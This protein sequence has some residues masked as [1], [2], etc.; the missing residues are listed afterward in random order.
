[1]LFSVI[2]LPTTWSRQCIS[3]GYPFCARGLSRWTSPQWTPSRPLLCLVGHG[4]NRGFRRTSFK[5]LIVAMVSY[6]ECVAG[7]CTAAYGGQIS[8]VDQKRPMGRLKKASHDLLCIGLPRLLTIHDLLYYDVPHPATCPRSTEKAHEWLWCSRGVPLLI[9]CLTGHCFWKHCII[10]MVADFTVDAHWNEGFGML[11]TSRLSLRVRFISR[12]LSLLV[13]S[14]SLFY[15]LASGKERKLARLKLLELS[16]TSRKR[17]NLKHA[18][19]IRKAT[20]Q[21]VSTCKQARQDEGKQARKQ[22]GKQ[23]HRSKHERKQEKKN[24]HVTHE[25]W[26]GKEIF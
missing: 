13:A 1:M 4:M 15:F 3:L 24:Q 25:V 26:E 21:A 7:G 8:R 18:G 10:G 22:E 23:A 9:F 16:G 5:W 2:P 14:G 6:R 17:D 19:K 12:W 11:S 20:T